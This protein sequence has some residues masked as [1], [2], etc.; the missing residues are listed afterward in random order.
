MHVA[1]SFDDLVPIISMSA[2]DF[3]NVVK[4]M[5]EKKRVEIHCEDSELIFLES[6]Q[7]I[8]IRAAKAYNK[9]S[10]ALGEIGKYTIV[11]DS[12]IPNI[13]WKNNNFTIILRLRDHSS[14]EP[15][16]ELDCLDHPTNAIFLHFNPF[17]TEEF[18]R[19]GIPFNF[20][21]VHFPDHY[22]SF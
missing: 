14:K 16:Y 13:D 6:L 15:F 10:G 2:L 22:F 17:V 19:E 11:P 4:S 3:E 18:K 8:F 21:G 7:P 1:D 5:E 9:V 20:L 12:V